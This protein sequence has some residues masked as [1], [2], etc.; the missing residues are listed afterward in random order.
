MVLLDVF[1]HLSSKYAFTLHVAHINYHLRGKD[2]D[3]D[4]K[5]VKSFC[6]ERNIPLHTLQARPLKKD[7]NT[8]RNIRFR[9]LRKI[10]AQTHSDAI[11]LAHHQ[12]DQAETL[13][14]HLFRGGGKRGLSGMRVKDNN[15][16]RPFLFL[17]KEDILTYAQNGNIPFRI[18]QSNKHS[19]FT[20]NTIRNIYLPLIRNTYPTISKLLAQTSLIMSEEDAFLEEITK[21]CI[22]EKTSTTIS[23]SFVQWKSLHKAIQRRFLRFC[24]FTLPHTSKNEISFSLIEELSNALE[25]PKSKKQ[26][27]TFAGLIFERSDDTI[28]LFVK[29]N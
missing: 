1:F 5:L 20:R 8:L 22:Y 18:D 2:S 29:E 19:K 9:F 17:S 24:I 10:L 21:Q 14:L 4:E 7:E 28:R 11:V 25:H 13:L 26:K 23:F 3:L 6:S 15:V 12:D 27:I 16:I